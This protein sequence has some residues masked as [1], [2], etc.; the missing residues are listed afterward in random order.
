MTDAEAPPG[1]R[2]T[3]TRL[4][5]AANSL[6]DE[7]GRPATGQVNVDLI[8]YDVTQP[9]PIPGDFGAIARDGRTVAS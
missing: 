2:G 1:A 6:V 5:I 8:G 4:Q 9:N 7:G 3:F